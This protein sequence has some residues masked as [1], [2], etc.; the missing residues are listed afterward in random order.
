[1]TGP[2]TM[3]TTN[4]TP[5]DPNTPIGTPPGAGRWTWDAKTQSWV[6]QADAP[7]PADQPAPKE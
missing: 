4:P 6:P 1:M 2:T 7:A 3:P 5:A